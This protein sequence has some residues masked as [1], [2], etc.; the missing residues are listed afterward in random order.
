MKYHAIRALTVTNGIP[1]IH[2]RRTEL[3]T[4]NTYYNRYVNNSALLSFSFR[5]SSIPETGHLVFIEDA[6]PFI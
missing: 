3:R 6:F 2:N 5:S 1:I 4:R